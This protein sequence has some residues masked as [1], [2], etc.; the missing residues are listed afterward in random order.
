V[1]MALSILLIRLVLGVVFLSAAISKAA[2]LRAFQDYLFPLFRQYSRIVALVTVGFEICLAAASPI[3]VTGSLWGWLAVAAL[4]A[5]TV[6]YAARLVMSEEAFCACWGTSADGEE[7]SV[8]RRALAPCVFGLRNAVLITAALLTVSPGSGY[9]EAE[10]VTRSVA[11][12][13]GCL[14]VVGLGVGCSILRQRS[15]GGT[16]WLVDY[17]SRWRHVSRCRRLGEAV[18]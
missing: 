12:L 6:A 3:L 4:A 8:V 15:L 17:A 11:G 2:R 18:E 1:R 13:A 16:L 5:F 9:S 14:I 7:R 10:V